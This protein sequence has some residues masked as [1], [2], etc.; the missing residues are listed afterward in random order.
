MLMEQITT[1][2]FENNIFRIKATSHRDNEVNL[3]HLKLYFIWSVRHPQM[4]CN[5]VYCVHF[6]VCIKN[7]LTKKS[8]NS[9]TLIICLSS[10]IYSLPWGL[11]TYLNQHY[12]SVWIWLCWTNT[13]VMRAC[14]A[15]SAF[16]KLIRCRLW[17]WHLEIWTQE[18]TLFIPWK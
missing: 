18:C 15:N 16:C 12:F 5:P 3:C 11:K 1:M 17:P 13:K 2:H 7:F 14:T 10:W 8:I 9:V 6:V 4:C